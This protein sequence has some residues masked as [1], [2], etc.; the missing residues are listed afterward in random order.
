M[1]DFPRLDSACVLFDGCRQKNGY[2]KVTVRGRQLYA[3]RVA[4]EQAFGPIPR[5]LLVMHKCD[6]RL[7]INPKHLSLGTHADNSA[8]MVLK[9]R[10]VTRPLVGDL[11]G[12]S[13][14]SDDQRRNIARDTRPDRVIAEEYGVARSTICGIKN[15]IRWNSQD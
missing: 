6:N 14:L 2:G 12:M 4:Y 7:C 9:G 11:N 8:D 5:G 15:N 10:Q 13:K 1:V 3:H